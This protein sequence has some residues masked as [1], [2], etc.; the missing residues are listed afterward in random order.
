MNLARKNLLENTINQSKLQ[1]NSR[2][3][4]RA[5]IKFSIRWEVFYFG[6]T[7]IDN[8]LEEKLAAS[9]SNFFKRKN[10]IFFRFESKRESYV[11]F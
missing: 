11:P 4:T 9:Q 10:P 1:K 3:K 5:P 8:F 7:Q 6:V 2:E